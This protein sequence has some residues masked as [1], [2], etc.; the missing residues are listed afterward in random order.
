MKSSVS[1]YYFPGLPSIAPD[2]HVINVLG[3]CSSC[4][5]GLGSNLRYTAGAHI[6]MNLVKLASALVCSGRAARLFKISGEVSWPIS[7][8]NGFPLSLVL[9]TTTLHR[10]FFTQRVISQTYEPMCRKG[11][12]KCPG[13]ALADF[14]KSSQEVIYA[15]E[16][17][18]MDS[19]LTVMICI[20]A[21]DQ[22]TCTMQRQ[23]VLI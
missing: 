22:H 3:V 4:S 20:K 8:E 16:H 5:S 19:V 13:N 10:T 15:L 17:F 14:Y 2:Q 7:D 6:S 11:K 9:R 23:F 12:K 18:I 21:Q 1:H